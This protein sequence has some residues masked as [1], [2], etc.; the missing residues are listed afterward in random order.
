MNGHFPAQPF[1]F[2]PFLGLHGVKNRSW[3]VYHVAISSLFSPKTGPNAAVNE[4]STDPSTVDVPLYFMSV[5]IELV[6]A[7]AAIAH[8]LLPC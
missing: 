1:G 6:Y 4:T 5:L 7:P 8:P 3:Y 2:G